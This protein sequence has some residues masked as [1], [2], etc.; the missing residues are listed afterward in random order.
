M[1]QRRVKFWKVIVRFVELGVGLTLAYLLLA[2]TTCGVADVYA[3]CG[4]P[5]S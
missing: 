5:S 4:V 1:D 2:G 3:F